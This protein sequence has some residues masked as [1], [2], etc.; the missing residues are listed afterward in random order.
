MEEMRNAAVASTTPNPLGGRANLV[1]N[2]QGMS[3]SNPP[4]AFDSNV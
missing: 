2:A 1:S 3:F 4:S